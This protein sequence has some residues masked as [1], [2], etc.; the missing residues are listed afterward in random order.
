MN[1][2]E[3][4]LMEWFRPCVVSSF[5]DD[6]G[7]AVV[8]KEERVALVAG[9]PNVGNTCFAAASL[10]FLKSAANV[11]WND[12]SFL[13]GG[14]QGDFPSFLRDMK[15]VRPGEKKKK[16]GK[17][18][19]GFSFSIAKHSA[20]AKDLIN[21]QQQDA[22]EFC[23]CLLD[24]KAEASFA[25]MI[26]TSISCP[27]GAQ[28][29]RREHTF[30]VTLPLPTN[31]LRAVEVTVHLFEA[32]IQVAVKVDRCCQIRELLAAVQELF[33]Q[34]PNLKL[35]DIHAGRIFR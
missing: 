29:S 33:P 21:G 34:Y 14:K 35:V 20:I 7:D 24:N 12:S 23:L 31:W 13:C 1:S 3:N 11:S 19:W 25:T 9:F 15:L 8:A 17:N 28:R 30:F 10:Q 32:P 22:A 2:G 6:E 16:E 26:D 18:V 27:C 4:V 5:D